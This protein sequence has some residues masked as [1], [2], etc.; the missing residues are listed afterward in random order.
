MRSAVRIALVV[1]V[2]IVALPLPAYAHTLG[3]EF[4]SFF[5]RIT[6][7]VPVT[8]RVNQTA[9]APEL[10]VVVRGGEELLIIGE[11]QE[12]FARIGPRGAFVSTSSPTWF[13]TENPNK[14]PP[15]SV[16]AQLPPVWKRVS[17]EPRFA[18]AEKRAEWPHDSPPEDVRRM[19]ERATILTWSIPARYGQTPVEIQGHVDWVPSP[20]MME[21]P[22]L[23]AAAFGWGVWRFVSAR[24]PEIEPAARALALATV[25]SLIVEL[26]LMLIELGG[27]P[28]GTSR[29]APELLVPGLALIAYSVR[30]LL[31]SNR[32]AIL[33]AAGFGAYMFLFG[34]ARFT[35]GVG[36]S[37]A[38]R[39]AL[40]IEM[41]LGLTLLF[42]GTWQGRLPE[43]RLGH[44]P[45]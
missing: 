39:S 37:T 36:T 33:A 32:A 44:R 25:A 21:L 13:L 30:F 4:V 43:H 38:L 34:L 1:A 28:P 26:T 31:R 15:P 6:P 14:N 23:L 45:V 27:R 3:P 19:G 16:S 7:S 10:E 42:V 5:D 29:L 40:V 12:P 18:Y 8:V 24:V 22:I 20:P 11:Q 35:S 41:L 9:D 17:Q 2:A